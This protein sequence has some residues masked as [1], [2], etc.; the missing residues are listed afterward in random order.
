M[1][2]NIKVIKDGK[3]GDER[4]FTITEVIQTQKVD[5]ESIY[6]LKA[7]RQNLVDQIAVIDQLIADMKAADI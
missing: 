5:V 7:K 3:I 4:S 6:N 1:A 2:R